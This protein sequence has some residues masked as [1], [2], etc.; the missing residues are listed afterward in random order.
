MAIDP[1]NYDILWAGTQNRRGIFKSTDGGNTWVEK[2]RGVLEDEGITFRGITIDPRSSN[3]VYAAAEI[4]S[5]VWAG[6]PRQG[7]SFDL[8]Q[9]VVYKTTDGGENWTAIWRGDNLARYIWIDPRNPDVLYVSTGIFDREAANSDK[10]KNAAGGVG[11]VKSTDGGK[12]WRA[13]NNGLKNLYIGTLFMHPTNPDILLAG[14]GV[15]AYREGAGVY[16]STN[17]G[18]TWTQVLSTREDPVTSVE[19]APSNPSIA[20]AGGDQNVFRSEDGGR[21]WQPMVRGN[22]GPPGAR[23]GFPIDFQ[24]DPRDPN[25]LFANAYGGGNFVSTDGGK[26]WQIASQG[27]TGAEMNAV[28]VDPTDSATVYAGGR[29]GFFKSTTGGVDWQPINFPPAD[30]LREDAAATV[31]PSDPQ[32]VLISDQMDGYIFTSR[33]GGKHW[34]TVMDFERQLQS[35]KADDSNDRM[36]GVNTIVFAP[37]DPKMVYAGF[38]VRWCVFFNTPK[39]CQVPTLGVHRSTDGGHTWQRMPGEG[40]GGQSVLALA[41]HPSDPNTLYAATGGKGVLKSADGGKT[42]ITIN[43]GTTSNYARTLAMDPTN[44]VLYVGTE[45]AAV[46]KSTDGGATWKQSSVGLDPNAAI[47]T[48]VIDPTKPQVLYAGDW[49]SGAYRS[50]DGGVRWVQINEGLR[51]RAIRGMA[52]SSD[53]KHLYAATQGEGVFRLDVGGEPLVSK[54]TPEST[55]TPTPPR[56]SQITV[57]V[58]TPTEAK[59]SGG[60]C[61]SGFILFALPLLA[62]WLGRRGGAQ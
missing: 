46:F 57:P 11:V 5:F 23:V 32:H 10:T 38:A 17:G 58:P 44:Q 61:P 36:Q 55:R 28:A 53:G 16:L 45:G 30:V 1:H 40:L 20:Y 31:D 3:I 15:N 14:A 13:V 42:W 24:V 29:S 52:I 21:T 39:Y 19:F 2:D 54:A 9:G 12:T 27:Y 6:A 43:K 8:T 62:L 50:E 49:H 41:V 22:W 25:R 4:S 37:S 7:R 26:T 33:D 34:Q 56:P 47:R 60:L 59:G 51:T 48:I 35:L 18:E